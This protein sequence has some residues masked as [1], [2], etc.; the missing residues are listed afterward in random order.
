MTTYFAC[1][2]SDADFL[3]FRTP[4]RSRAGLEHDVVVDKRSGRV[5]CSC[6]A[7]AY[8]VRTGGDLL[9]PRPPGACHHVCAFCATV[10]K[11]VARALGKEG[12]G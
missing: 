12:R 2:G 8:K 9:D 11:I 3:Y 10:G 4:S 1:Q 6:E 7:C 5:S